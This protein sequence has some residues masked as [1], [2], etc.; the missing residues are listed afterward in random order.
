MDNKFWHVEYKLPKGFKW[1]DGEKYKAFIE[2]YHHHKYSRTFVL[3]EI[4]NDL[5]IKGAMYNVKKDTNPIL[6]IKD[7]KYVPIHD[8]QMEFNESHTLC[9]ILLQYYHERGIYCGLMVPVLHD[10]IPNTKNMLSNTK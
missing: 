3:L 2:M 4:N 6:V 10:V 8:I 7:W 9:N 1:K 5:Y